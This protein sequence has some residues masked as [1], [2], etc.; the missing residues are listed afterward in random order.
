MIV[1]AAMADPSFVAAAKPAMQI[2]A[3]GGANGNAGGGNGNA[4]G[5]SRQSLV[6]LTSLKSVKPTAP[7]VPSTT[8]QIAKQQPYAESIV[9]GGYASVFNAN[10]PAH[11]SQFG[12]EAHPMAGTMIKLLATD[13]AHPSSAPQLVGSGMTDDQGNFQLSY[14]PPAAFGSGK[15]YIYSISIQDGYFMLPANSFSIPGGAAGGSGA[16]SYDLGEIKAL[17]NTFRLLAFAD[18]TARAELTMAVIGVYRR[19][20]FYTTNP[21]LKTEGNMDENNR[22][23]ETIDGQSYVK[24]STINDA[25]TGTRL[26]YSSGNTDEYKVKVVA[27]DYSTY[28]GSLAVTT[29]TTRP[30]TPQTVQEIYQL[31]PAP[32]T[33][34]GTVSQTIGNTVKQSIPGAIVTLY[35]SDTAY[36]NAWPAHRMPV[37]MTTAVNGDVAKSYGLTTTGGNAGSG[38]GSGAAPKP[39][40]GLVNPGAIGMTA[41]VRNNNLVRA[42]GQTPAPSAGSGAQGGG[43]SGNPI[44][45]KIVSSRRFGEQYGAIIQKPDERDDGQFGRLYHVQC[46]DQPEPYALCRQRT[47]QRSSRLGHDPAEYGRHEPKSGCGVQLYCLCGYGPCGRR[48]SKPHSE[49]PVF[50]GF[51]RLAQYGR[52]QRL[53]RDH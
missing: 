34:S 5:M 36:Q 15:S 27:Q 23:T 25:Y 42:G 29:V 46:S 20:D 9:S 4:G 33:F 2:L 19:A 52:R 17:A 24:V 7:I 18:D 1:G 39:G 51:G 35:L 43:Q 12:N 47:G 31:L 11:F 41:V 44:A 6:T 37:M 49:G 26:F 21:A 13:S 22:M 40:A 30:T 32:T 53:F 3:G 14:V 28:T 50:L 38:V 48:A 45:M 16:A 10:D 8:Q